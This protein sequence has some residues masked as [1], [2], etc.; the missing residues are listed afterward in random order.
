M[1]LVAFRFFAELI[2]FLPTA[3]DAQPLEHTFP[4]DASVKDRIEALGVPHPEVAAIEVNGQ[5]V[6]F[7]YLVQHRDEIAVYPAS[8]RPSPQHEALLRPPYSGDCCF[9]LDAHLGKLANYLRMLGFDTLYRNDYSD[10]TLSAIAHQEE[11]ILLTRDL[12]LLK[13]REVIYG[14]FV[15]DLDPQMQIAEVSQRF[16]LLDQIT[17]FH[18]CIAC[19][20]ELT[21]V[22]KEE[23][24]TQLQP[25]TQRYYEDFFQCQSCQQIYWQGSHF[26]RMQQFIEQLRQTGAQS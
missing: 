23:I 8:Q 24:L 4:G 25:K 26:T 9:V 7:D 15:R 17:P 10:E 2:D 6:G 14:Y 11:R 1:P 19:N 5:A 13:R 22:A 3:E 16:H 20:G 12:G 21:A 18:R